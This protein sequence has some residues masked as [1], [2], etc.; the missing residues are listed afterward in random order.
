M[1]RRLLPVFALSAG[2]AAGCALPPGPSDPAAGATVYRIG[3]P[4]DAAL[5]ARLIG[6]GPNTVTGRASIRL[7]DGRTVSCAGQA[8]YL[9]PATAYA[10]IRIKALYG[11]DQRGAMLDSRNHRF[12]PDPP[13]YSRLVRRSQCNERGE[14]RFE[15]VASGNFF[16]TA[17]VRGPE[18]ERHAGGSLMQALGT[19]GGRTTDLSMIR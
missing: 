9:V 19:G 8:V 11:S 13:E 5:A 17:V 16:L 18:G 14:F 12:E 7:R 6:H 2:L 1:N 3:T 10:R 4:F 15:Q